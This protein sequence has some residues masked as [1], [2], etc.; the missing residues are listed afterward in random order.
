M[1]DL[2][3][4]NVTN[5]KM[6]WLP[7][8]PKPNH[9]KPCWCGGVARCLGRVGPSQARYCARMVKGSGVFCWQHGG[10]NE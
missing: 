10:S 8:C 9:I 7:N 6:T 4:N 3:N 1:S 2:S 5:V